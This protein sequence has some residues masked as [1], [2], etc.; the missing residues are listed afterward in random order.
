MTGRVGKQERRQ[1]P[2][3]P[4]TTRGVDGNS[5]SLISTMISLNGLD[6]KST[7]TCSRVEVGSQPPPARYVLFKFI[8]RQ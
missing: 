5:R 3:S 4:A 1:A 7:W 2:A 6:F 8:F